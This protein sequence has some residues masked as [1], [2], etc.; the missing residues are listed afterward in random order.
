MQARIESL[1]AEND[2]I[3]QE[4]QQ[5]TVQLAAVSE[6]AAAAEAL[7]GRPAQEVE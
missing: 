7:L 1:E 5:M 2:R 4:R 6:R 3:R